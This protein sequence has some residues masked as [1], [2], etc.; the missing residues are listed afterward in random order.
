MKNIF[1]S[2]FCGLMGLG[3][4]YL[5]F[6]CHDRRV[7]V[8][9][10]STETFQEN[11][12]TDDKV[13]IV[14]SESS[15]QKPDN[16]LNLMELAKEE[17]ITLLPSDVVEKVLTYSM[18]KLGSE[19]DNPSVFV[20]RFLSELEAGNSDM[21]PDSY[22]ELWISKSSTS[23]VGDLSLTLDKSDSIY[24]HMKFSG[25]L[26]F[27]SNK[28]MTR[29]L[30]V[31]TGKV[32]FFDVSTIRSQIDSNWVSVVPDGGWKSGSYSVTLYLLKSDLPKLAETTF[33][34]DL[35]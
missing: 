14:D 7:N 13:S 26:G 9:S 15:V 34:V 10:C 6:H 35:E 1:M 16:H 32:V 28:V 33:Y 11:K 12:Y 29:W 5:L 24:A 17:I 3:L 19:I 21:H 8:S 25:G 18:P 23:Q 4:G 20:T 30:N 31:D 2:F 27:G 22:A